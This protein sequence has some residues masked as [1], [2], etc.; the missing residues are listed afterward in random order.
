M[1][2]TGTA[3]V[4]STFVTDAITVSR[5]QHFKADALQQTASHF[6]VTIYD[7]NCY[8]YVISA[9]IVS[10][11]TYLQQ[12]RPFFKNST[13]FQEHNTGERKEGNC[14]FVLTSTILPL[15][16]AGGP[17]GG[18]CSW[19]TQ[20]WAG[21]GASW[22]RSRGRPCWSNGSGGCFVIVLVASARITLSSQCQWEC[23][24]VLCRS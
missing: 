15:Y 12:A 8:Y 24:S 2:T 16:H 21:C 9:S 22:H 14:S 3:C 5:A 11:G 13:Q 17:H 6:V 7:K 18:R 4:P 10:S 23:A 19:C 20:C 1:H